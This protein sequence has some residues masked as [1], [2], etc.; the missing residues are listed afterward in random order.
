MKFK[1]YLREIR[2]KNNLTQNDI[3]NI[4]DISL[5]AVK[6]IEAGKT[7]YPS[8]KVLEA[9][10]K[11]LKKNPAEIMKDLLFD[12][13][14]ESKYDERLMEAINLIQK[15]AAFMY[16]EGWNIKEFLP[17]F[18]MDVLEDESFGAELTSV[19]VPTYNLI[20]DAAYKY[21]VDKWNINDKDSIKGFISL[22]VTTLTQIKKKIKAFNVIFDA[23]NKY[24]LD[25]YNKLKSVYIRNFNI[26]L[27]FVLF[28]SIKYEVVDEKDICEEQ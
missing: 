6:K 27:K 17:V 16:V 9:L 8:S 4:L 13:I 28:D 3:S 18:E 26:K 10:A 25:F 14:D 2:I 15:Y 20:V 5:S 23:N 21:L 22:L 19:R 1:D 12:E 24:E 7:E 11:Y